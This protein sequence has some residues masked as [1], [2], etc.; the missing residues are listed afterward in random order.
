[1][2]SE[3]LQV[4]LDDFDFPY[5]HRRS[6]MSAFRSLLGLE[7]HRNATTLRDIVAQGLGAT[8][9]NG[10]KRIHTKQFLRCLKRYVALKIDRAL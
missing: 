4:N 1:M 5:N 7:S 2:S 10:A 9:R 3:H 6:P 8:G